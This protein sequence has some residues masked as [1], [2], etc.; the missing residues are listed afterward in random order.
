MAPRQRKLLA[1][2][3]ASVSNAL[4]NNNGSNPNATYLGVSTSTWQ[5]WYTWAIVGA[6]IIAVAIIAILVLWCCGC[7]VCSACC[8]CCR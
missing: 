8:C 6:C 4:F 2:P 1:D 5:T 3:I 7:F